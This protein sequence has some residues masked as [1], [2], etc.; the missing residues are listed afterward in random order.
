LM[1]KA[2][3]IEYQYPLLDVK[4]IELFYNL[5]SNLK[6]RNGIGRYIYRRAMKDIL[7]EEICWRVD[8]SNNSI[9]N[10]QFRFKKDLAKF[11]E[12]ISYGQENFNYH[13]VDYNKLKLMI[14]QLLLRDRRVNSNIANSMLFTHIRILVLQ[15]WQREGKID[16]GIKC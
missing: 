10:V 15:K 9:P 4:L 3:R 5:P 6:F 13:Y 7:P 2:N 1:A 14:D 8:K 11:Y 16:I 12:I